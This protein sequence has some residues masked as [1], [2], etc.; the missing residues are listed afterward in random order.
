MPH[1][2]FLP[3]LVVARLCALDLSPSTGADDGAV[4][5][6]EALV[7]L[8]FTLRLLLPDAVAAVLPCLSGCGD[9]GNSSAAEEEVDASE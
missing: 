8:D 7:A 1:A 2:A 3:D 6:S 4:V 9:E 5:A